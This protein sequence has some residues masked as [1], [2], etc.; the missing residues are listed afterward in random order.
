MLGILK[1]IIFGVQPRRDRQVLEY[2]GLDIENAK[3]VHIG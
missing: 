1:G 2:F 3:S